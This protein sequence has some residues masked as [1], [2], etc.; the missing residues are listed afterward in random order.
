M[1]SRLRSYSRLRDLPATLIPISLL[2][3]LVVAAPPAARGELE[4]GQ[5]R[6]AP[7]SLAPPE[8]TS[9]SF[10]DQRHMAGDW[11][12]FRTWLEDRGITSTAT[13]V[14]DVLGNPTGGERHGVRETDNFGLEITIDMDRL[15]GWPGSR[16]HVSFSGRSGTSLTTED[17]GNVFEVAQVC[18]G[19]TYRLVDVSLDQSLLDDAFNVWIGRIA[20]GDDFLASP[21][22]TNFV[23]SG[24][25]GNPAGILFDVPISIYPVATWG[26][27]V[28]V[29]PVKSVYVMAGA[30]NGDPTLGKNGKHGVDWSM[31]GP[32]FAIGEI[33]YRLNQEPGATGLPGNYKL[34]GFYQ[35]GD[36][37]DF[38]R[39]PQGGVAVLSGLPPRVHHGNGGFYFLL[40]QMVYRPGGPESQRGLTPFVSLIFSPDQSINTM[41]FFANGGLVYRGPFSSR[42]RDAAA[43][44]VLYGEFSRQLQRSQRDAQRI[45]AGP[46]PQRY[47][48]ALE[49][50]Y[51]IQATGWLQ[52][53][54]DLQ[55]IVNPGGTGKINGALVIGFQLAV[56]L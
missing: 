38:L 28:R 25:N 18:C 4:P 49:L 11:G 43:F 7:F 51:I 47:E 33:G 26:A 1:T 15:A 13:F 55:Y 10:L 5:P 53:Q 37:P 9:V 32:L 48:L 56:S 19:H 27:R 41:P 44:G 16:F 52:V 36:F 6:E 21:L 17:I 45:G 23:Q 46:A 39:D 54:P 35:G 24:F 30:Y 40:D 31:R 20:A 34:G 42:P 2:I 29:T 22:Y 3:W 14:T 12:G 8:S 50:T